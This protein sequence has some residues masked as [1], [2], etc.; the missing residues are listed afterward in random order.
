MYATITRRSSSIA[1]KTDYLA[2]YYRCWDLLGALAKTHPGTCTTSSITADLRPDQSQPDWS[3]AALSVNESAADLEALG[4]APS[5]IISQLV[6]ML[7][8]DGWYGTAAGRQEGGATV[9]EMEK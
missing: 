6:E 7:Q 1:V 8:Q 4:L 2:A 9:W 5:M 3:M